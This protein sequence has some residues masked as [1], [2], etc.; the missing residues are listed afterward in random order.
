MSVSSANTSSPATMP[1]GSTQKYNETQLNAAETTA[2]NKLAACLFVYENP[3]YIEDVI[4]KMQY[5]HMHSRLRVF[6]EA[7]DAS[8]RDVPSENPFPAPEQETDEDDDDYDDRLQEWLDGMYSAN[9]PNVEFPSDFC[10]EPG[11]WNSDEFAQVWVRHGHCMIC[12]THENCPHQQLAREA[13][14][15]YDTH[16]D[17][18]VDEWLGHYDGLD[19]DWRED[20][21]ETKKRSREAFEN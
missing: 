12:S 5:L 16:T 8:T 17:D 20:F 10:M 11:E 2:M 1:F 15:V 13:E 9:W 21:Q 4:E 18:Y 3:S 14:I 19:E 7:F 6:G